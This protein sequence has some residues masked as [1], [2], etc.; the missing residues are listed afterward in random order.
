M[1]LKLGS[2]SMSFSGSEKQVRRLSNMRNFFSDKKSA[3]SALKSSD[4]IIYEVYVVEPADADGLSYAITV[5][6]PG[7][8]GGEF[9]MTKGHFHTKPT[10]EVYLGLDGSGVLLMQDRS[11]KSMKMGIQPGKICYVPSG[12][13]HR[14]VNTGSGP[15]KFLAVYRSDSGHDYGTIEKEGFKEKLMK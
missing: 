8:V 12:Y 2:F 6:S 5:I 9:F 11:G 4:P 10:G 13:A 7:D 1:E 15:L 3:E 14:V